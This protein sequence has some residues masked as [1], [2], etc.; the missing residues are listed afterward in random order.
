LLRLDWNSLGDWL[1]RLELLRLGWNHSWSSL[2]GWL[3]GNSLRLRELEEGLLCGGLGSWSWLGRL[4]LERL[5][6][7]ELRPWQ[8]G[9]ES[10]SGLSGDWSL[11]RGWEGEPFKVVEEVE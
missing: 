5:L 7:V 10:W 2:G 11:D 9:L 4:G 8:L 1:G 6:K 3:G